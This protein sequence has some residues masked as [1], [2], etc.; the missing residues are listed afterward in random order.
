M[1]KLLNVCMK[2]GKSFPINTCTQFG[3][4]LGG[5]KFFWG[6]REGEFAPSPAKK[7][8]WNKHCSIGL[9]TFTAEWFLFYH[10]QNSTIR[11]IEFYRK[12]QA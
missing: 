10:I 1:C 4:R 12:Q 8:A 3:S 11:H 5:C 9:F 7:D 6:L 2:L